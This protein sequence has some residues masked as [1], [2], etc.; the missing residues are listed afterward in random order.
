MA[1]PGP[2]PSH[3]AARGGEA[4]LTRG[5]HGNTPPGGVRAEI[6][7]RGSE[8][9]AIDRTCER[10]S[11]WERPRPGYLL[12]LSC[13]VRAV[14]RHELKRGNIEPCIIQHLLHV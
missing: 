7:G 5:E 4:S 9:N 8:T 2:S 10:R 12:K 11:R 13:K 1:T 6:R 3:D 14:I